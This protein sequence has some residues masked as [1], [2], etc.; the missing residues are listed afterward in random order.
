[1]TGSASKLRSV[2][3]FDAKGALGAKTGHFRRKAHPV[4]AALL[5]TALIARKC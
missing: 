4:I 3:S 5:G 1:M 2:R